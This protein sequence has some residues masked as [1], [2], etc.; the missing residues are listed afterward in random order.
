[1]SSAQLEP[2]NEKKCLD[3]RCQYYKN[4]KAKILTVC[5]K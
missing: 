2:P 3:M 5:A 1:M 4:K